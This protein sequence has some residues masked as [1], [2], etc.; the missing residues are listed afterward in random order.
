MIK[1]YAHRTWRIG[2][3]VGSLVAIALTLAAGMRW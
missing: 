1:D 2:L 3:T